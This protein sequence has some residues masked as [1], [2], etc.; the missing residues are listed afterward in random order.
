[1]PSNSTTRIDVVVRVVDEVL[2]E[3]SAQDTLIVVTAIPSGGT[4][5]ALPA[6]PISGDWYE[7]ADGDGS[8]SSLAPLTVAVTGAGQT[9]QG[10]SSFVLDTPYASAGVR[11]DE[12]SRSWIVFEAGGGGASDEGETVIRVP[13]T[14]ASPSPL[15]LH[16]IPAASAVNRCALVITTAFDDA[17]ATLAVGTPFSPAVLLA[18]ADNVPGALGQYESDSIVPF[19][20]PENL[21]LTLSPGASTQGAG[22]VLLKEQ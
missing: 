3:V 14:F 2:Y 22:Y 12:T 16:A 1:M 4:I 18:T 15:L 11:Y 19:T 6:D 17:A 7:A 5:V 21:I 8:C 10:A 9:I 13:F 20:P